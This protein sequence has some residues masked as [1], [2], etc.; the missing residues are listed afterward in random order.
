MARPRRRPRVGRCPPE[1]GAAR[2]WSHWLPATPGRPAVDQLRPAG[3]DHQER[4]SVARSTSSSMKSSSP[5]SAQWRS[6]NTSTARLARRAPRGRLARRRTIRPPPY[7]CR[8]R[9]GSGRRWRSTHLKVVPCALRRPDRA[10]R[11][12]RRVVPLE[13]AGP[14]LDDLAE[15]PEG[16]ALAIGERAARPPDDLPI[17]HTSKLGQQARLADPWHS[18][19]GYQPDLAP[20]D[21]TRECVLKRVEL[22]GAAEERGL[23]ATARVRWGPRSEHLPG[24][25]P[26]GPPAAW[27]RIDRPVLEH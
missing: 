23:I 1:A 21:R 13:D 16:D 17:D 5:S 22:R 7:R 19:D 14:L 26:F 18:D 25:D 24:S 9:P 27:R 6:S 11:R 10:S 4:R 2:W 12:A 20:L 8:R 15:R 3:A